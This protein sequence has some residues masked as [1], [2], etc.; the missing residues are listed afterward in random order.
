M[1]AEGLGDPAHSKDYARR[2]AGE[3]ERLGRVVA[4][5]L[6]FTRLERGTLRVRPVPGDLAAAVRDCVARQ[7]ASLEAA[8]ARVETALA[9]NLPPVR[10]D[11]DAVAEI[12]QNLLDNAE[13]YSRGSADRAI[14]VTLVRDD[15]EVALAV[16][17]HGSGVSVAVRRRLFQPFARGSG[18]DSPAGLGLGLALVQ[19]LARAQGAQVSCD[20]AP[21]GGAVF[22]VKFPIK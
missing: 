8:S 1:L 16:A 9:D 22:T 10:F 15:N 7:Q 3:V 17:D 11:R 18:V 13:K 2:I 20:D 21:G 5:M 4:N 12:L 6:G 14:R 19:A